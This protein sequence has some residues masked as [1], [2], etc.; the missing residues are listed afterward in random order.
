MSDTPRTDAAAAFRYG[1]IDCRWVSES[2]ARD[3][4]RELAAALEEN[5]R[6]VEGLQYELKL[7]KIADEAYDSKEPSARTHRLT[8]L[9]EPEKPS[10][11]ALMSAGQQACINLQNALLKE[12]GI[13]T[14]PL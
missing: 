4:E 13:K 3:I 6:L 14:P 1:R 5:G 7:S 11:H 12:A 8:T 10:A 9:L 2:W